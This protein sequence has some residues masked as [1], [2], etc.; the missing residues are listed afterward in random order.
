VPPGF[1]IS[2]KDL[3]NDQQLQACIK[4]KIP[5]PPNPMLMEQCEMQ[6]LNRPSGPSFHGGKF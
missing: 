4:K 1:G 5:S 6:S 3:C 2:P